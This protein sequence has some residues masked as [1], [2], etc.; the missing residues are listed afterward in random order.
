[1]V[2][3]QLLGDESCEDMKWQDMRGCGGSSSYACGVT[4]ILQIGSIQGPGPTTT[5]GHQRPRSPMQV[6]TVLEY[7]QSLEDF[8]DS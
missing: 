1:M 6:M 2:A 4:I 5:H 3:S 8:R 7:F